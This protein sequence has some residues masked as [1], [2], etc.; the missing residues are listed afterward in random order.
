MTITGLLADINENLQEVMSYSTIGG[1]EEA[2]FELVVD[3]TELDT[4]NTLLYDTITRI[5]TELNRIPGE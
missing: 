3:K 4:I 5:V 1:Q 2:A